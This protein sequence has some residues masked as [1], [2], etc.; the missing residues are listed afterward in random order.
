[1]ITYRLG[2][3]LYVALTNRCTTTPVFVTRGPGFKI[4]PDKFAP[5]SEGFEPAPPQVLEAV[6]AAVRE[7]SPDSIV[8]AGYGEPTLCLPC[9]LEVCQVRPLAASLPW[10]A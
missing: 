3:G 10:T 1:M 6:E 4:S 2:R 8:F 5:L 9:M 7:S